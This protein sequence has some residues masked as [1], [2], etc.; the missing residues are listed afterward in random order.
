MN[1]G[2]RYLSSKQKLGVE[3]VEGERDGG[4]TKEE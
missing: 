4:T 2:F 3:G 1:E